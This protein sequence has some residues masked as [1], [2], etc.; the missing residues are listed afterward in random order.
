MIKEEKID[1]FKTKIYYLNN[2]VQ[3]GFIIIEKL[4]EVINIIDVFVEEEFRNQRIAT[5]LFEYLL[6]NYKSLCERF[7]LEVNINNKYAIKLYENFGFKI[8]HKRPKYYGNDDAL[9][10]EM[11]VK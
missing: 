5:K 6:D 10:M 2:N 7:M 11:K 1:E 8:I 4:Y 3:C 9:I